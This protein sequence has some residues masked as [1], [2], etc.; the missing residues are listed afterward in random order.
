MFIDTW[1]C[2]FQIKLN[3]TNVN[4]YFVFVIKI[5]DCPTHIIHENKCLTTHE[6]KIISSK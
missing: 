3:I 1:I 5:V 4:K 6:I 2:G